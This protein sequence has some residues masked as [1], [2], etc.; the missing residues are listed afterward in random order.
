VP[1]EPREGADQLAR[2]RRRPA[3][4]AD[5]GADADAH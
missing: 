1:A 2:V 4:H 5:Q 3:E